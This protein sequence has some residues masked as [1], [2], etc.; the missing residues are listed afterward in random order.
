MRSLS[1]RRRSDGPMYSRPSS[2]YTRRKSSTEFS[3]SP[4]VKRTWIS[5]KVFSTMSW[6]RNRCT[7]SVG[8]SPGPPKYMMTPSG[9][10]AEGNRG[11]SLSPWQQARR[12]RS[13]LACLVVFLIAAAT[14]S[15]GTNARA[16]L[17]LR[18]SSC[19]DLFLGSGL[20]A[21]FTGAVCAMMTSAAKGADSGL[22]IGNILLRLIPGDGIRNTILTVPSLLG[23]HRSKSSTESF[24]PAPEVSSQS[25]ATTALISTLSGCVM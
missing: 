25:F 10:T 14:R 6:A 9:F 23:M 2:V 17:A 18:D 15:N 13:Y 21:G 7:P 22:R 1:S 8:D 5:S 24:A 3:G 4:A 20:A 11:K 16:P 19:P 12:T